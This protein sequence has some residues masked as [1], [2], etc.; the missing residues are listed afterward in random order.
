MRFPYQR[1]EYIRFLDDTIAKG[2]NAIEMNVLMHD[3]QANNPPFAGGN[4]AA[5]FLRQ[6]D[7]ESWSG[8]LNTTAPDASK[9]ASRNDQ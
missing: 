6:L 8:A 2:F 7:G 3:S 4:G 1:R 5:P 9:N